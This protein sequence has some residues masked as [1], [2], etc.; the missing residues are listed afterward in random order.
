L[1]KNESEPLVSVPAGVPARV[2]KS[3]TPAER[4]VMGV[5]LVSSTGVSLLLQLAIIR[6]AIAIVKYLF[7]IFFV[8][9]FVFQFFMFTDPSL[10]SG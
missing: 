10:R 3:A 2:L 6:A 4:M 7:F 1:K 8:F 5:S 9:L